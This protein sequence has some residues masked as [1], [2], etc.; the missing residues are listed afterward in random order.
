MTVH[1]RKKPLRPLP[2]VWVYN[3]FDSFMKFHSSVFLQA[4][5]SNYFVCAIV[6][7]Q[8]HMQFH[9]GLSPIVKF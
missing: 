2:K 5:S 3:E 9:K 6:N 4:N 1:E 8:N 7:L